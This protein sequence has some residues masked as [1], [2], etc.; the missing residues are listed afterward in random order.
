MK[1]PNEINFMKIH[2]TWINWSLENR[3][4]LRKKIALATEEEKIEI[5]K[6]SAL[7]NMFLNRRNNDVVFK[8]IIYH[9]ILTD[10]SIYQKL[11]PQ[12]TGILSKELT[13]AQEIT[14]LL[15]EGVP[16]ANVIS[17]FEDNQT[18]TAKLMGT[19]EEAIQYLKLLFQHYMNNNDLENAQNVKTFLTEYISGI[20]KV[21]DLFQSTLD[22]S[23]T[24]YPL[25]Y[26]FLARSFLIKNIRNYLSYDNSVYTHQDFN[27]QLS[28]LF[29]YP[30]KTRLKKLAFEIL[31]LEQEEGIFSQYPI[32][33]N[34]LLS[35]ISLLYFTELNITQK[36]ELLNSSIELDNLI[37]LLKEYDYE[38]DFINWKF[39]SSSLIKA[40]LNELA[41]QLNNIILQYH[42]DKITDEDKF[43]LYDGLGTIN[44]N[45]GNYEKASKNFEEA[46]K[47]VDVASLKGTFPRLDEKEDH[48]FDM[49]RLYQ[50]GVLLKNIGENLGHIN[51]YV[52]MT[53][54]FNEVV[55]LLQILENTYEKFRLLVNLAVAYRR[56][57]KFE[58]EREYLNKA[59]DFTDDTTPLEQ[60][61]QRIRIFEETEMSSNKLLELENEEKVNLYY[62]S[63]VF[64]SKINNLKLSIVYNNRSLKKSEKLSNQLVKN[65][66]FIYR[67][68]F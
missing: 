34:H 24:N 43:F 37:E 56:L 44:R 45:L 48:I 65:T 58:E 2:F 7:D 31:G 22:Y 52:E 50:K 25:K 21:S 38:W 30:L 36:I 8:N 59:L 9:K 11:M 63:S 68:R 54:K 62:S 41:Y 14:Q 64:L 12:I 3:K 46:L 42:Y 32:F 4:I 39:S 60:I 49:S 66:I 61:E 19:N 29:S 55:N 28:S 53:S 15:K 13:Y 35:I 51:K 6:H 57:G 26:E 10:K 47:W 16:K 40:G 18:K 67:K 17:P 23:E 20:F 5:A 27:T 1:I 33:F